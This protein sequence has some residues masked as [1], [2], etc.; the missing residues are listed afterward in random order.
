MRAPAVS[1]VIALVVLTGCSSILGID[2]LQG[3]S[4]AG[5]AATGDTPPPDDA[6][7]DQ[8]VV[9]STI[10]LT[11]VVTRSDNFSPVPNTTIRF[12]RLPGNSE[13]ANT[14]TLGD[15]AYQLDLPTGG[16]PVAGYFKIGPDSTGAIPEN[17]LYLVEPLVMDGTN[18][19]MV[20]YPGA[21]ISQMR[22]ACGTGINPNAAVVVAMVIDANDKPVAGAT[23]EAE[24][25][26]PVCYSGSASVTGS[27]GAAIFANAPIAPTQL[28]VRLPGGMMVGPRTV[29]VDRPGSF[30]LIGMR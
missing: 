16:D 10:R 23:V 30:H 6:P 12:L 28:V 20:V 7:V 22:Q 3:P 15:G 26:S 18:Y 29:V 24:P 21:N 13:L 17:N 8:L 5:D 1:P 2:D 9:P 14:T 27:D 11:G 19:T 4:A 25:A